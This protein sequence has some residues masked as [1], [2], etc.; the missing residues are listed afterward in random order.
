MS[1][2]SIDQDAELLFRENKVSLAEILH[3]LN[4]IN[5][6]QLTQTHKAKLELLQNFLPTFIEGSFA[7]YLTICPHSTRHYLPTITASR[8]EPVTPNKLDL[9]FDTFYRF[10]KEKFFHTEQ[11]LGSEI[12]IFSFYDKNVSSLS[13]Q[14]LNK[15]LYNDLTLTPERF[16]I[17]D[18]R[19]A[20]FKNE[21][22][23]LIDE[24]KTE[25]SACT[26]GI[27]TLQKELAVIKQDLNFVK[28][29]KAFT[30]MLQEKRREKNIS[31]LACIVLATLPIVIP[32][33]LVL[34]HSKFNF[35]TLDFNT[36]QDLLTV[37]NALAFLPLATIEIISIYYF[38]ILLQQFYNTK[39]QVLQLKLRAAICEFIEEYG[40]F[41]EENKFAD[42]HY[43]KQ[44]ESLIFSPIVANPDQIPNT[45][46]GIEQIG[47]A[48]KSCIPK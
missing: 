34:A 43:F 38:R 12:G 2:S 45:L 23:A 20:S 32:A 19:T 3:S 39:G 25:L 22:K 9:I 6:E 28:L 29:S 42:K 14:D 11:I 5:K 24:K 7:N 33:L 47:K 27:E 31:L 17:E 8:K 15:K 10:I 40:K 46:D 4:S 44:F 37:Q 35:S 30:S 16:D 36:L 21:I 41:I 18:R 1:E 13:D 26:K 48:I